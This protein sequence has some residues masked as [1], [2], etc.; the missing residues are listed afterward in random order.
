MGI[1][2]KTTRLGGLADPILKDLY[3]W[4]WLEH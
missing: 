1:L 2:C 3:D 4:L